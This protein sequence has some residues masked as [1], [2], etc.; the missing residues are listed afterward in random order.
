MTQQLLTQRQN[1]L[2]EDYLTK[3][4]EEMKRAGKVKIYKDVM[5]SLEEDEP[6]A[7]APQSR[8][9]FPVK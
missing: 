7:A 3:V 4:E 5:A 9:P 2:W 8:F 1:Q 6:P